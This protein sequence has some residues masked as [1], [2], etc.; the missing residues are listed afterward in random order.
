MKQIIAT[1]T[2]AV[3]F[4]I[5]GIGDAQAQSK[6]TASAEGALVIPT[7]DWSD[8]S[9]IGIGAFVRAGMQLQPKLEVTG[10]LGYVFHLSK[11]QG[12]ADASTRELMILG[13][14]RYDLGPVFLDAAT[15]INS[16]TFEVDSP[17]VDGSNT[18]TRV[19]LLVGAAV[20]VGKVEVGGSLLIPN[21]LLRE[22]NE[23][24]MMGIM[25][26]VGYRFL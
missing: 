24:M 8:I 20:P 2:F 6:I 25:G 22:D 21:L 15:G 11:D 1:G 3:L 5:A 19:P 7:G 18:E 17:L 26:M 10:R 16:W 9:G 23:D 13:G 12:G 4:A 14:V